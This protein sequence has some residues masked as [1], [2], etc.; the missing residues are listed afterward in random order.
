MSKEQNS[1]E[2]LSTIA[3]GFYENVNSEDKNKQSGDQSNQSE[4]N[5]YENDEKENKEEIKK[6]CDDPAAKRKKGVDLFMLSIKRAADERAKGI[7]HVVVPDFSQKVKSVV[8]D[9]SANKDESPTPGVVTG[10]LPI[11]NLESNPTMTAPRFE[12]EE[13]SEEERKLF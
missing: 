3:E 11:L 13:T 1:D 6:K 7:S 8:S 10:K 5:K 12:F 4:Q 2:T 9:I